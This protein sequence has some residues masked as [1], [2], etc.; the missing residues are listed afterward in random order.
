[1][2]PSQYVVHLCRQLAFNLKIQVLLHCGPNDR[3]EVK[4][5]CNQVGS[6]LVQ[7]MGDWPDLPIEVSIAVL[8]SA[9][10]VVSSDS[11]PRHMA[12]ALDKQVISLFGSTDPEPTRT[13][14]KPE[15]ILQSFEECRP[16]YHSECPLKHHHCMRNIEVDTVR[17]AIEQLL[18]ATGQLRICA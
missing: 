5:V 2:W 15:M 8:A 13:Y 9:D 18:S 17:E 3:E 6:P 1:M 12:V 14:N 10:I 7:S 11:G 16:C 4:S